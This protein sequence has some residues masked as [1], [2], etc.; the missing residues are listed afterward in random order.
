MII[1]FIVV[2]GFIIIVIDYLLWQPSADRFYHEG[3]TIILGHRGACRNTKENT[4]SAILAAFNDGA[5]GVEV[6]IMSTRDKKIILHHDHIVRTP[7][8]GEEFISDMTLD[9]IRSLDQCSSGNTT[10]DELTMIPQLQQIFQDIPDRKFV[11]L[12]I[13]T[14]RWMTCGFEKDLVSEIINRTMDDRTLLSSFNPFVIRKLKRIS[15]KIQTGFIWQ[16]GRSGIFSKFPVFFAWLAKADAIHL[17]IHS[18][19]AKVLNQ[20]RRA[21]LKINFW[22][23]NTK[24][25]LESAILFN[26]DG[27]ITDDINYILENT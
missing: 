4:R 26:A 18:V 1:I 7:Q 12:E 6:D 13:K 27:I 19:S 9:D 25:E 2:T 5:D 16:G 8:L 17:H 22:T 14:R 10:K 15:N 23:V 3:K 11:N 20:C 21:G 24:T